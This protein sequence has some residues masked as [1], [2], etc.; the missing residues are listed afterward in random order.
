MA[1]LVHGAQAVAAEAARF[2]KLGLSNPVVLV[3]GN[4]GLVSRRPEGRLFAMLGFTT[5]GGKV[6]EID[7]LAD[8]DR[9][10]AF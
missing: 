5:A 4:V 1:H 8:P 6:V 7:I 3:N 9:L 2:S 10:L